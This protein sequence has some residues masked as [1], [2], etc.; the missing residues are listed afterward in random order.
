M[1]TR[2]VLGTLL[3]LGV[4]LPPLGPP[5]LAAGS[6][7]AGRAIPLSREPRVPSLQPQGIDC[8][9]EPHEVADVSIAIGGIVE[10]V[11][12]QRGD[13][14]ERGQVLA[15][16]ESSVEKATV[17]LARARAEARHLIRARGARA[18][19]TRRRLERHKELLNKKAISYQDVD[20][21]ETDS[22]LAQMELEQAVE[23]QR[24]ARL[25]LKRAQKS[26]ALRTIR[27][28][29]RGVVVEVFITPGESVE[30]RPIVQIAQVDPLNVEAIA[31]VRLFG[32]VKRGMRAEV[33]PE[34]PIGGIHQARVSI[35]DQVIDAPSGTFGVR[36]ELPNSQYTLPAGLRCRVYFQTEGEGE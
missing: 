26:L 22:I 20:E 6:F 2:F 24:I 9:I 31:P 27:S 30:D 1:I 25:E 13:R 15:I 29:V 34:D 23:E 16:L 28:P 7:D 11:E 4:S 21:A 35:V 19:Y 32:T 3:G 17:E 33:R 36:L 12:V 8:V 5:A 14:V 10:T 18:E